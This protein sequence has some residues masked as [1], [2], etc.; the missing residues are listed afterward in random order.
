M[1]LDDPALPD[2]FEAYARSILVQYPELRARWHVTSR[3][4]GRWLTVP[5]RDD[6]GFDVVVQA[7]TDG[8]YPFAGDW[9]GAPWDAG[10]G[11]ERDEDL[12]VRFMGFVRSLLCE[13]SRLDVAYAGTRPYRWVLTYRTEEGTESETTGSL[14]F[15]YFAK[16]TRRTFQNRHPS[17]RYQRA[18]S[19]T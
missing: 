6:A 11:G 19:P 10:I 9:H 3:G 5:K 12:C 1:A 4:R 17:S 15:N 8:L 7:E 18:A 13:D 2:L 14:F 16:R